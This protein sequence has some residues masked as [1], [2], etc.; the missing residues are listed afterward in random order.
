MNR[1]QLISIVLDV[2]AMDLPDGAFFAMLEDLTGMD[3]ID[4]FTEI[5]G[6]EE[7]MGDE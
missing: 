5:E 7:V 6:C 3:A 1:E 2:E 4:V